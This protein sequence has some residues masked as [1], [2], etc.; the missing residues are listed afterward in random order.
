MERIDFCKE[1]R[2]EDIA[3]FPL[4]FFFASEYQQQCQIFRDKLDNL[5]PRFPL[6]I[7]DVK[8]FAKDLT[9]LEDLKNLLFEM[10]AHLHLKGPGLAEIIGL[11][12]EQANSMLNPF[13]NGETQKPDWQNIR[14]IL[15]TLHNLI[16]YDRTP[17]K[18]PLAT[19]SGSNAHSS[20]SSSNP[21]TPTCSSTPL[22]S[23]AS[24]AIT[25]I[26]LLSPSSQI[27]SSAPTE[28]P[29]Q[30]QVRES[31]KPILFP[32]FPLKTKPEILLRGEKEK[33]P[34]VSPN[35]IYQAVSE[36]EGDSTND[37]ERRLDQTHIDQ[38][39]C[40][41]H[42]YQQH[43]SLPRIFCQKCGDVKFLN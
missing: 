15:L 18:P 22:G 23:N 41:P 4:F 40:P 33:K 34:P 37:L 19:P 17:V 42:N 32:P 8:L 26:G 21:P 5:V 2:T 20:T 35:Q 25:T 9:K 3:T 1:K 6:S 29:S 24:P 10:Q 31:P 30:T 39:L 11:Q 38:T 7:P 27:P 13:L 36:T 14:T 12:R 43:Q 28:L 16:F